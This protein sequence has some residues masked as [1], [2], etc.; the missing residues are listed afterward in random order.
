MAIVY[1]CLNLSYA[2]T[3]GHSLIITIVKCLTQKSFFL[4]FYAIVHSSKIC[5]WMLKWKI[6]HFSAE[7]L[8][9]V[10][11]W[12]S[13]GYRVHFQQTWSIF[14]NYPSALKYWH[15]QAVKHSGANRQMCII[16][17]GNTINDPNLSF[18]FIFYLLELRTWASVYKCNK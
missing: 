16:F 15:K 3:S 6:L 9:T 1:F 5:C 7:I 18:K 8:L 13:F 10:I 12:C 14:V 4:F 2:H 11:S 17:W